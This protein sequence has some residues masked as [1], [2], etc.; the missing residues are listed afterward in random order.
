MTEPLISIIVPV[1]RVESYLSRCVDSLLAQT[2]QNLEIIL[3]DDGSPDQCPAICDACAEKDARVKV[4]H[5]ENKGLSGARNAGIDAASGEYLAFVD[6]DDYVSPHFIEELYQLLQDTGCAIGQCRFSYVKGDGLVEEGDSAFCIYRGESLMEQ[7][8]GPEE[9]ATC[10]VVAWNKLYRAELF[11]ETGIRYPE[12]RIHED[13]A[14]TYRLFHEA[15]KLAFLDRALYG[16]YTENGGSIT[17]VF[18]AK[19]LQWLTAHEE[20]IA[21][22]KKNGYEKLLPAAYRKLCDACI[23]FYFRCT[24]QVKDAEEL[25]KELRKRLETYRANGAA[26]IAALPLKTRMG[27]E[28]FSMSPGLYAKMLQKMQETS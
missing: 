3:V 1:Y 7:L 18:S 5:Q 15:K 2:Y 8:Y 27:Y 22:F 16:Y 4:I 24:E 9:K 12:G 28:L 10:F 6:S 25:K 23:T 20:R 21:F 14:T 26:W 11:K 17:S 13:E 19:R